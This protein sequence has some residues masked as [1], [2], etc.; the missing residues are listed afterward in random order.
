[1]DP[2]A[3]PNWLH[4]LL[5][6][7]MILLIMTGRR[8]GGYE[9][10]LRARQ[11][12]ASMRAALIAEFTALRGVYR[13]N[14]ELIAAGAP[15]LIAAKHYFSIYRGNMQRL[16]LLSPAETAAVVQAH[17]AS[18]TLESA[19]LIGLRM[20]HRPSGAAWDARGLDLWRLLRTARNAATEALVLLEYEADRA[21]AETAAGWW[22]RM[23]AW[24]AALRPQRAIGARGVAVAPGE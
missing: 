18:Q 14:G 9:A 7:V 6:L 1:M 8:G 17:A 5:L 13:L 12:R 22:Q 21:E 19:M 20:R 2:M 15:Q 3:A 16:L 10:R 23:R 4:S 24:I 11:E